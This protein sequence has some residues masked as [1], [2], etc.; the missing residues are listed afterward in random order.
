[1]TFAIQTAAG[2]DETAVTFWSRAE[3]VVV[4]V[5]LAVLTNALVGPLLAPNQGDVA[6]GAALRIIWLPV[7]GVA[8]AVSLLHAGRMRRVWPA[9]LICAV[10]LAWPI[11]S[12][13]WSLDPDT[14]QRRCI[15]LVFT[16]L[17]GLMLAARYS[18]RQLVTLLA[19]TFGVLALMSLVA[20]L[21]FPAWGI[22]HTTNPN[23]WK[24]VWYEKNAMGANMALGG[25][26]ALS[27]ALIEPAR[28]RLWVSTLILC[29]VLIVLSHSATSLLVLV[30]GGGI[31]TA[32]GLI[33][34][35]PVWAVA[36]AWIAV[37]GA[38]LIA[39]TAWLAPELLLKAIGKD[40]TL[41]GRTDIW[42]SILRR[43]QESPWL[44][45]G[46]QAFWSIDRHGPAA[47]IRR[48]THWTVPSAHNGWLELL[49]QLG[50]IGVALFALNYL[51]TVGTAVA[52]ARRRPDGGFALVYLAVFGVFSLSESYIL[53]HNSISWVLYVAVMAKVFE[54]APALV[55]GRVRA[56]S[57]MAAPAL[58]GSGA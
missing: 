39:A 4:G 40:P 1:M 33:R 10:L 46:Y 2:L 27:A 20:G 44:G 15:A 49:I 22:N 38:G 58:S 16:T 3:R 50:A 51:L 9:A 13:V 30:L 56:A 36:T 54:R 31:I 32:L 52:G 5:A 48:E 45:Y 37:Q 21:L 19:G 47:I 7:Y 34:R 41:T 23:D 24:G 43:V 8:V 57:G 42:A 25:L 55:A 26:A 11:A 17:F 12:I 6:E 18:W 28:R 53:Q 29:A 14:T 35:G